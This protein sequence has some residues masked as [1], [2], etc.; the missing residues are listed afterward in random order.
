MAIEEQSI[1]QDT[2]PPEDE[3]SKTDLWKRIDY[4]RSLIEK[5]AME[6]DASMEKVIAE[7]RGITRGIF[8][9]LVAESE[10]QEKKLE[11]KIN[12]SIKKIIDDHLIIKNRVDKLIDEQNRKIEAKMRSF[13]D[14]AETLVQDLSSDLFAEL[15]IK[16][17]EIRKDFEQLKDGLETAVA[18]YQLETR[19][20]FST[21]DA[22]LEKVIETLKKFFKEI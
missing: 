20:K 7:S 3:I 14:S 12:A 16:I 6:T 17:D 19:S 8:N 11:E 5:R 15:S 22:K 10:K 1:I 18:Q 2:I 21:L 13:N 4:T 9:D